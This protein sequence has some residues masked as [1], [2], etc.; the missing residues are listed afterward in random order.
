MSV[1]YYN[2]GVTNDII[3]AFEAGGLTNF[4]GILRGAPL[5]QPTFCP[6][7][8]TGGCTA[9]QL[10]TATTPVGSI[11]ELTFPT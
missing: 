2:V 6:P 10:V 3:S 8:N 11:L 1:D 9:S 7:S 5:V 4:S